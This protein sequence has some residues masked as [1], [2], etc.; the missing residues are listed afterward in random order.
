MNG[1][2]LRTNEYRRAVSSENTKE[3]LQDERYQFQQVQQQ[4]TLQ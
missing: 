4:E 3:E 1:R 2:L